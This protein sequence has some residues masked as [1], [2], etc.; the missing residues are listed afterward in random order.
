M[1]WLLP[2]L[3]QD[4]SDVAQGERAELAVLE[5][6]VQVLLEH[7]KHQ[8]GVTFVLEAFVRTHKVV[9][10]CIFCTQPVQDAHL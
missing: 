7:L 9:L 2:N 8:A 6:V 10:I 1:E 5:E 4:G 3:L